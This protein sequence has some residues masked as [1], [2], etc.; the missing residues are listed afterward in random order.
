MK[1]TIVL[2]TEY[3]ALIKLLEAST[4]VHICGNQLRK[5]MAVPHS[6]FGLFGQQT[7]TGTLQQK[8]TKTVVQLCARPP[9]AVTAI[10]AVL[11]G[12]CFVFAVLTIFGKCA[13]LFCLLLS[14]FTGIRILLTIWE[15]KTCLAD[16]AQYLM[17][18]SPLDCQDM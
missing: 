1:K 16:F 7:I 18:K 8:E 11:I 15:V 9:I 10:L 12:A 4:D 2:N 5:S 13:P 6:G 3:A 14:L 17:R